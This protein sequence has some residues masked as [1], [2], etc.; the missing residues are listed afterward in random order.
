MA[1]QPL[2]YE[3]PEF[4]DSNDARPIRILATADEEV[5]GIEGAKWLAEHQ[6]E[7]AGGEFLLTEGSFARAGPK[8][9][10]ANASNSWRTSASSRRVGRKRWV[11]KVATP[12]SVT[13][14][15]RESSSGSTSNALR[16]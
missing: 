13:D 6:L 7:E 3:Y 14:T 1:Q 9:S 5:G 4:L 8:S 2:A 15:P 11:P 12:G 16:L 10:S